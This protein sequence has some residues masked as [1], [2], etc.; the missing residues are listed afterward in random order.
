MKDQFRLVNVFTNY[1]ARRPV[2]AEP[3]FI[4]RFHGWGTEELCDGDSCCAQSVGIVEDGEGAIHMVLPDHIVF[5]K[6]LFGEYLVA[7]L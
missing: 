1:P 6:N 4:G 3:L 7:D 5:Q 2:D